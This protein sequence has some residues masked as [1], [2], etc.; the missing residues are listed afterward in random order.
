MNKYEQAIEILK[1]Y[2]QNRVLIELEN[3]KNEE[4]IKQVLSINFQQIE[5]IKT[6]IEEE[7]Q[8]KFANDTIEKIECIDGNKLSSEEKREYEDIGNK[9]IKEEKY[10]VVTMAGGQRNKA[11]T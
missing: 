2:K 7:K 11:W 4:L 8:K 5:N 10:A 9:V 3:N 6:K 1:K